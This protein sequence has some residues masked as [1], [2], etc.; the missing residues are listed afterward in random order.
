VS[1]LRIDIECATALVGPRRSQ[2]VAVFAGGELLANWDFS[3]TENHASRS[4]T[5]PAA[6][7]V[8][9]DWGFPLLRLEFRPREVAPIIELD[10]ATRD[11]RLLGL[12]LFAIR[13]C[14]QDGAQRMGVDDA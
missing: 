11:S 10:P 3:V 13:R 1:D 4:V 7:F 12:A 5:I 9:G 14:L 2:N 8:P 6:A